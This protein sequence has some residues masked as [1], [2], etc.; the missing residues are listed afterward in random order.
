MDE[1]KGMAKKPGRCNKAIRAVC[2]INT[3]IY[4]RH[5]QG[6]LLHRFIYLLPG[7]KL[8][9]MKH[10]EHSQPS[11]AQDIKYFQTE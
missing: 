5:K 1:S 10:L 4:L 7:L 9:I 3:I 8:N 6:K 11:N 2:R